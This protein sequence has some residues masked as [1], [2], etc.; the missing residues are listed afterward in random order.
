MN[1]KK[2]KI[3]F[4]SEIK[5]PYN[6]DM[7]KSF[8]QA[9]SIICDYND[10][11]KRSRL[12]EKSKKQEQL[13]GALSNNFNYRLHTGKIISGNRVFTFLSETE[14]GYD[15]VYNPTGLKISVKHSKQK[16]AVYMKNSISNKSVPTNIDYVFITTTGNYKKPGVLY[17]TDFDSMRDNNRIITNEKS[18][19]L[20]YQIHFDDIIHYVKYEYKPISY[21]QKKQISN[22]ENKF[23]RQI[24]NLFYN[25]YME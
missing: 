20:S 16:M 13:F 14:N 22:Q 3:I 5:D 23:D 10:Y 12:A 11:N 9:C 18:S 25:V 15:W 19:K 4:E 2:A 7:F 21:N 1:R 24:V 8:G 17:I 6:Q